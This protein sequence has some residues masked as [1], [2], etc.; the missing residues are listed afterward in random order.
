MPAERGPPHARQCRDPV[1]TLPRSSVPL[2]RGNW[3]HF[4]GLSKVNSRVRPDGSNRAV[5][6]IET[7]AL[8]LRPWTDAGVARQPD[9]H[10]PLCWGRVARQPLWVGLRAPFS[11]MCCGV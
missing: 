2:L 5:M 10:T 4:Q 7:V 3:G 9:L 11:T 8:R 6:Q 1:D